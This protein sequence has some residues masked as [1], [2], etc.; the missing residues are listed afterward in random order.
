MGEDGG[1]Y[2]RRDSDRL[3]HR[4]LG[5]VSETLTWGLKSVRPDCNGGSPVPRFESGQ[6]HIPLGWRT[7]EKLTL[8]RTVSQETPVDQGSGFGGFAFLGINQQDPACEECEV[9]LFSKGGRKGRYIPN[10]TPG[11]R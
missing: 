3:D 10:S 9:L 6:L 7:R 5:M 4:F 8:A 2:S 1:C 11:L